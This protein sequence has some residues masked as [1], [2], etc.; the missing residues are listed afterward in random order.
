MFRKWG[1]SKK[2]VISFGTENR[3]KLKLLDFGAFQKFM[4]MPSRGKYLLHILFEAFQVPS[5]IQFFALC[6]GLVL[7]N[8]DQSKA[9]FSPSGDQF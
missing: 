5:R 3:E 2:H 7:G 1:T 4:Q 9:G 6:F 8:Y